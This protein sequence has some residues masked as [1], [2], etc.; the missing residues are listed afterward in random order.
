[1]EETA[2]ILDNI[3][4]QEVQ[5]ST[6]KKA[7]MNLVDII[8]EIGIIVAFYFLMPRDLIMSLLDKGQFMKYIIS[9]VLILGYRFVSIMLFGKTPGMF[10]ARIKFLNRNLQQLEVKQKLLAVLAA[11]AAGINYYNA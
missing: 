2:S 11:K 4:T 9:V 10:I 6:G 5:A 7:M 3:V 8:L 1:M